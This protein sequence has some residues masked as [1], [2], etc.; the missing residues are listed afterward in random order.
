MVDCLGD[1]LFE[2][3]VEE[4]EFIKDF[5]DFFGFNYYI[6]MLVFDVMG[7]EIQVVVYGN[8]GIFEDQDVMLY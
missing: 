6:I 2:F 3:I 4:I 8:G 5:S 7:K 1:C